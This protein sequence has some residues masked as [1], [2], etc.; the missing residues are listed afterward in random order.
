M[1][2][3]PRPTVLL[4]D[5]DGTL[6]ST[7]GAGRRAMERAFVEARGSADTLSF[8]FGG[9]TDRA[10][11]RR[12]LDVGLAP[13]TDDEIEALLARYLARLAE[14]LPASRGFVV[15]DGA[16]ALVRAA[17]AHAGVAVGLGTG[18]L[19]EGARLKLE[20]AGLFDAFGFGGFGCDDEARPRL[21]RVGADRGAAALGVEPAACRVV[22]IGDT[23][24]DIAAARAIGAEVVAV[25]TGGTPSTSLR[26]AEPDLLVET[27]LDRRVSR[28][29]LR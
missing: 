18:N 8:S 28:F 14:E 25:A 10:I 23:A 24:R 17:S 4:F 9:M 27:L 16:E 1:P 19:R 26:A 3:A 5:V 29:L 20:R 13:V 21:L 15:H 11:A 6:V 7:G 22:V 12:G 2:R